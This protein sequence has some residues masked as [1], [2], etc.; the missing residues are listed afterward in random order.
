MMQY[1]IKNMFPKP[2]WGAWRNVP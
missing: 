2:T 1:V